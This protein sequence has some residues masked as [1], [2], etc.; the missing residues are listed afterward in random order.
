MR[1]PTPFTNLTSVW[2]SSTEMMINEAEFTAED[3]KVAEKEPSRDRV[4]TP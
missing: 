2:R 1:G 3:A 4:R